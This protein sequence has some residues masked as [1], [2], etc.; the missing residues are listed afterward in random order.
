MQKLSTIIIHIHLGFL[1]DA[2]G[3]DDGADDDAIRFKALL[4]PLWHH[5]W[6]SQV[7]GT[8]ELNNISRTW[9]FTAASSPSH[10]DSFGSGA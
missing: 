8:S 6:R 7:F 5:P 2:N 4:P 1:D 10:L 3:G 9:R